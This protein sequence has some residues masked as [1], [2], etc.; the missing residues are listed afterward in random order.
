[1]TKESDLCNTPEWLML[2]FKDM[3]DPCPPN[4]SF[5]GL[6]IDWKPLNYVNPPYSD[7]TPWILKAIQEK[8]KGNHSIMLLKVDPSTKWYKL[9]MENDVHIAYFNERIK[10]VHQVNGEFKSSNNFCSMLV[11]I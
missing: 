9:L 8:G 6:N 2:N 5:D 11:F 3:F 4:P 1:M 10:F 7:V